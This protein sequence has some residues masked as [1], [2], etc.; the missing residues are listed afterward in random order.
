VKMR[1]S[2]VWMRSSRV[3]VRSSRV[4]MRSSR[5]WMRSTLD[6]W[7]WDLAEC[8]WDLAVCGWDLAEW[9]WDLAECGWDLAERLE[10]L[11]AIAK[12][13]TVLFDPSILWYSGI[14]GTADEAVLKKVHKKPKKS[15]C[16]NIYGFTGFCPMRKP[17]SSCLPQLGAQ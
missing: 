5:V 6:E 8:G 15:R 7:R 11:T 12:V 4:R 2:R 9:G 10:R 13:A 14:W 3:W 16:S 17:T 1:S